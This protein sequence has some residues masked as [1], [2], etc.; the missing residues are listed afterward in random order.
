MVV[1]FSSDGEKLWESRKPGLVDVVS[2][3][4]CRGFGV[5][6]GE[7]SLDSFVFNGCSNG[8]CSLFDGVVVGVTC[9][10][11]DRV[12]SDIVG[13]LLG[14]DY[15]SGLAAGVFYW[16]VAPGEASG[17]GLWFSL[18]GAYEELSSAYLKFEAYGFGDVFLDWLLWFY[19]NNLAGLGL[20]DASRKLKS[21]VKEL[22]RLLDEFRSRA[23]VDG[24]RGFL[25]AVSGGDPGFLLDALRDA[26]SGVLRVEAV[27]E[28]GVYRVC[29]RGFFPVT[30]VVDG[31]LRSIPPGGCVDAG[32]P[33]VVEV[34]APGVGSRSVEIGGDKPIRVE[35]VEAHRKVREEAPPRG[36]LGYGQAPLEDE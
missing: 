28:G 13:F 19:E 20:L 11:E 22:S 2:G 25:E 3:V 31:F 12:L 4:D 16:G 36:L 14:R 10:S 1:V 21:A 32:G 24:V 17:A 26:V 35:P 5:L 29:N 8:L 6:S 7:V 15:S 30:G 27:V 18:L 34:S 9:P 23:G 33:G